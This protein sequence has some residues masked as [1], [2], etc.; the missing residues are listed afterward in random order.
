MSAGGLWEDGPIQTRKGRE[1][2]GR[3]THKLCLSICPRWGSGARKPMN[4]V[5]FGVHFSLFL[6][7]SFYS[8]TFLLRYSFLFLNL[9]LPFPSFLQRWHKWP[10]AQS[11]RTQHALVPHPNQPIEMLL[12]LQQKI[13]L[14]F[15]VFT[16]S[17]SEMC[18]QNEICYTSGI[19]GGFFSVVWHH[20]GGGFNIQC[21]IPPTGFWNSYLK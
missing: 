7:C 13:E 17:W 12:L 9:T 6:P 5:K 21:Q 11:P 20:L 14:Y 15:L 1:I 3:D 4:L 19:F 18:A 8:P 16:H 10:A 2:L